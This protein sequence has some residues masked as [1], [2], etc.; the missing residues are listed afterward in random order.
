[1]LRWVLFKIGNLGIRSRLYL[2]TTIIKTERHIELDPITD[3][4]AS[5]YRISM[6]SLSNESECPESVTLD[7]DSTTDVPT[8]LFITLRI[9]NGVYTGGCCQDQRT[10]FFRR[11]TVVETP[12]TMLG[13]DSITASNLTTLAIFIQRRCRNGGEVPWPTMGSMCCL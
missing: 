2:N 9:S 6:I 4:F 10:S 3:I 1:M 11:F 8:C 7:I 5:A 12:Q 13:A